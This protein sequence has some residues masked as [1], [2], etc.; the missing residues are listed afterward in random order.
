MAKIWLLSL[1]ALVAVVAF[2][3]YVPKIPSHELRRSPSP[4]GNTVAVLVEVGKEG[5]GAQNYRV[6]LQ[7]PGLPTALVGCREVAYLA[8]VGHGSSQPPVQLAWTAPS[9]LEIRYPSAT[10]IHIYKPVFVWGSRRFYPSRYGIS[11]PIFIKAV[12]SGEAPPD[13]SASSH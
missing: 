4:D 13:V 1:A 6:C 9:Q 3:T 11:L 10:S 12:Q 8:G 7:R 5:L 2:I